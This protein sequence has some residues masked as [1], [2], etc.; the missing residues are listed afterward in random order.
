MA[1][2]MSS[3]APRTDCHDEDCWLPQTV[4]GATMGAVGAS[5]LIAGAITAGGSA[6]AAEER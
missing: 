2:G 3:L 6:R 5:L 1:V 4:S